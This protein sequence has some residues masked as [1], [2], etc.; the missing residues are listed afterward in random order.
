MRLSLWILLVGLVACS[1]Q[2]NPA[3]SH[4][5]QTTPE[6]KVYLAKK[7]VTM[8]EEL[9]EATAIAVQDGKIAAIGNLESIQQ[10][11]GEQ[12]FSV[13]NSYADNILYPGF[14]DNHLHPTLAGILFPS[15]FITPFDWSL[16]QREVSGI[17]NADDYF[18][19]LKTKLDQSDKTKPFITWGY[20]HYFHGELTRAQLDKLSPEQPVIVWHRSFHEIVVNS[21]LLL[22]LEL[23]QEDFA[24]HPAVNFDKG[25]FW[26]LGLFSIFN[27]LAPIVLEPKRYHEG[28]RLGLEHA[29]TN[30]ITSVV[31]QGFPLL[32]FDMELAQLD[33]ALTQHQLPLEVFIVGNGKTL[34]LDGLDKGLARLEALP[35][36]NTDK[37]QFL[38]KQVKLLADGAFY[39]QLM[40]M[41]EPYLDG[42]HGEWITPPD[43]LQKTAATFWNAGYQLH[44]HVNGDLGV[45]TVLDT[46]E[47]LQKD[48]P[49]TN[50]TVF[51]HYGFSAPEHAARLAKLDVIVSANPYY[52]YALADKYSEIGL[53]KER[54]QAITRLGDL[55]RNKVSVSLHSDLP[56]APASPL[57]LAGVAA[58]RTSASGKV[59]LSEQ[60]LSKRAALA[61]VTI[62]A[63]QAVGLDDRIGSL[64]VGKQADFVVLEQDPLKLEPVQWKNIKIIT[65][66]KHGN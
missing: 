39:S 15:E 9:A 14:I 27:K 16:P 50:S 55:E 33:S 8:Q 11:L 57:T 19:E 10:D 51:H 37:I 18:A 13:D 52:L 44:I 34:S 64:K 2:E 35:E 65:T 47:K 20:H 1:G 41:R 63:A 17:A 45:D 22:L 42:H 28:V 40:Q 38:P 43:E 32:D 36:H 46:I 12:T 23:K 5:D 61:G 6:I 54:A 56:M 26:E 53:G 21:A 3:D 25:H 58:S 4:V 49:S 24:N 48:Q 30:G 29:R 62:A 60:R 59:H 31:D 66:I 7:I